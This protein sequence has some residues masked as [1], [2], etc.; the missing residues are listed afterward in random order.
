M[1]H[2]LVVGC[3]VWGVPEL[4]THFLPLCL[5]CEAVQD[6]HAGLSPGAPGRG[7]DGQGMKNTAVTSCSPALKVFVISKSTK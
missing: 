2:L 7:S 3:F 6:L 1:K 5:T 4:P